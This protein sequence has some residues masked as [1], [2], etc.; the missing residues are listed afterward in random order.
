MA[1]STAQVSRSRDLDKLLLRPG[2]L[3][4]PA[5]E[6]GPEVIAPLSEILSHTV[7]LHCCST[8]STEAN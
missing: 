6:P 4:D 8:K 1:D 7:A 3:V 5:F 2:N